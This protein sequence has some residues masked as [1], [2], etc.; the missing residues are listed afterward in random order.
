MGLHLYSVFFELQING[1]LWKF[2]YNVFQTENLKSP[3]AWN[4]GKSLQLLNV[5]HIIQITVFL[6]SV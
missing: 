1:K 5:D 2:T 6:T 3:K 4:S